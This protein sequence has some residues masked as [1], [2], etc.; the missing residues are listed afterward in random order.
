VK[1]DNRLWIL[2]ASIL[3]LGLL[4]G[5]W[6]VGVSPQ[7][8]A[9]AASEA[10]RD[11]V[12]AQNDAIRSTLDELRAASENQ[13]EIEARLAD[14]QRSVPPGIY[15][16]QFLAE[17]NE[18]VSSSGVVITSVVLGN[19]ARYEAPAPPEVEQ[20][21]EGDA[22]A[23]ETTDVEPEV[24]QAAGPVAP[25][26][27]TD[28]LISSANFITVPVTLE[29]QGSTAAVLAFTKSLQQGDRLVL[30]TKVDMTREQ[31][32]GGVTDQFTMSLGGDMYVLETAASPAAEPAA[33]EAAE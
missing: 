12:N 18:I 7:L 1:L 28:S 16:S 24:V 23:E 19:P 2:I 22:S 29:V 27:Q 14:L 21:T 17:I 6:F 4:A 11:T 8:Q 5:G 25:Q 31:G 33:A 20:S 30:V 3:S 15:G 9:A 10:Q 13:T 32:E 26:P